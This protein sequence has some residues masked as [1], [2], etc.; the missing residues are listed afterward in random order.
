MMDYD[1]C[2]V[3]GNLGI[4][5][6][7]VDFGH[8][9]FGKAFPCPSCWR[10]AERRQKYIRKMSHLDSHQEKT[11]ATFQ[12]DLPWLT[13][14]QVLHLR[15]VYEEVEKYARS[16][17]GWLVLH[18][19]YGVGKTHLAA[20]VAHEC[21]RRNEYTL[22]ATVPDLLDHL[23]SSYSPSADVSYDQQFEQMRT[24]RVLVLDDLGTES[25]TP[26]AQEK[27]YQLIDHRYSSKLPTIITTNVPLGDLEPRLASRIFDRNLSVVLPINVP[28]F[29]QG[30]QVGQNA[31]I[32]EL[33]DLSR[34]RG[35]TFDKIN[36]RVP[37]G[38]ESLERAVRQLQDYAQNPD[39]WRILVG[40]FGAGKTHLAAAT[41]QAWQQHPAHSQTALMVRTADLLDYL[42]STFEP[43][44]KVSLNNRFNEI[45]SAPLLIL[46]D[47][48]LHS[49]TAVWSREKLFQL[50]D[51]RY[52]TKLPTIFT[53]ASAYLN[54]LESE[55][56]DFHSRLN[57]R[58]ISRWL[59]L[60]TTDYRRLYQKI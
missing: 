29:R 36:F 53:L 3:C 40:Q 33:S 43:N 16:P 15:A 10:G 50:V 45:K 60:E 18:G 57:D 26:W 46:E 58:R 21:V 2:D 49:K 13:H 35:M 37:E 27:L 51:Y 38:Q 32:S 6:K 11:F 47:F 4:V 30:A 59:I 7:D 17:Q 14:P 54:T 22:F 20:A 19:G 25:S 55:H 56:P 1:N 23:R 52:L 24:V 8:P 31:E 9:D 41:A 42:R 28:D 5:Y 44:S 12:L 48:H 34:Y 39:G